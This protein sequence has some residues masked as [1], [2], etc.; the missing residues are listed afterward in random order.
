MKPS[1][2]ETS[3]P[4]VAGYY[5]P[6]APREFSGQKQYIQHWLLTFTQTT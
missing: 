1:F 2:P 5:Q 6:I 3:D 4:G